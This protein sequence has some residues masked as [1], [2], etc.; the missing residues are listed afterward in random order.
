[1]LPKVLPLPLPLPLCF[2]ALPPRPSC[3]DLACQQGMPSHALEAVILNQKLARLASRTLHSCN[4]RLGTQRQ[5]QR[6]V[7]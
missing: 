4:E 3:P 2:C 7:E 6:C 1:M 5:G